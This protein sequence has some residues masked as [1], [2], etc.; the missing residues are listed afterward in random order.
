M[1]TQN[2]Q[3]SLF[4]PLSKEFTQE[5]LNDKNEPVIY[6]MPSYQISYFEPH[7]AFLMEKHL[8]NA[9]ADERDAPLYDRLTDLKEI[10]KEIRVESL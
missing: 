10:R 6:T 2:K 4:N 7:I 3:I 8:A 9:V 1:K 5:L